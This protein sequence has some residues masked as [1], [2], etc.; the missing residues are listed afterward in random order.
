MLELKNINYTK[1]DV[2]RILEE[3]E[4]TQKWII[5]NWDVVCNGCSSKSIKEIEMNCI[6][7]QI[8]INCLRKVW[9]DW[10]D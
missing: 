5:D 10:K 3:Y 1:I 4:E 9:T 7:S 8:I 2:Q 6:D